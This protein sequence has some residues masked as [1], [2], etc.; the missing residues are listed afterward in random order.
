MNF[1]IIALSALFMVATV[2]II[3]GAYNVR[4]IMPREDREYLDPLPF[5]LRPIWP[6]VNLIATYFG[7]RLPVDELERQ[8]KMLQRSGLDYLFTPEQLFG[9]QVISAVCFSAGCWIVMSVLGNAGFLPVSLA[10]L[11]GA[12]FPRI[13]LG[14]YRKKREGN[15]IKHLPT[16]LDFLVLTVEAGLNLTA[17]LAQAVKKG[18]IGPL[19][20]EFSRVLR[21]IKAGKPKLDA[22]R[23]MDDRLGVKEVSSFVSALVQAEK[24]GASIGDTLAIQA[25]QRRVERFQRAEK[26][27]LEAPVKLVFPLVAFIFPVTFIIIGFPIVMK[28]LYEV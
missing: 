12:V 17:G 6:L 3:F 8:A 28:F 19:Q 22:L 23:A 10:A 27:A 25:E 13:S 14:D 20:Y 18:P 4:K 11:F 2:L 24:S 15:I 7:E 16:Y 1:S 9:I 21:E 5:L 26:K